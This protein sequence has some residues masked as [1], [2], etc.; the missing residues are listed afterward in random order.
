[1]KI[2]LA[3][4]NKNKTREIKEIFKDLNI[5]FL[6]LDDINFKYKMPPEDQNTFKGNS[7]KKA[8]FV[9]E[10]TKLC[11]LSDD[12]GLVIKSLN[13]E[14]G[15]NSKRYSGGTNEDNINLV[16]QKLNNLPKSKRK[17]YFETSLSLVIPNKDLTKTKVISVS[18]KVKGTI[19]TK[20]HGEN[21]F[22]YDP[23]FVPN[24][25]KNETFGT[26]DA[27]IKNE[28]SHRKMALNKI[29]KHIKKLSK[30]IKPTKL[31]N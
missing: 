24:K 30:K 1:M 7:I 22:G 8:L 6:D 4:N 27:S 23:I 11:T 15:V 25:Y 14:P 18:G 26:L 9:S 31:Q 17:A 20:K 10:K 5:E 12:S 29:K 16:L 13:N 2:I 21:G 19:A 3:T 28:I